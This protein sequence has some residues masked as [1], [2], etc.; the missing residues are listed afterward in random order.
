MC[1]NTF[2]SMRRLAG[3]VVT[4]AVGVLLAGCA[5]LGN[6][7]MPGSAPMDSRNPSLKDQLTPVVATY[8]TPTVTKAS[9]TAT[10]R[11][12]SPPRPPAKAVI[13]G[14]TAG[15]EP[16]DGCL[17]RLKALLDEPGRKWV[18]QPQSPVEHAD[19]TRQFAYRALRMKLTCNELALA[20]DQIVAATK[21]FRTSVQGVASDQVARIRTLDAQIEAELRAERASRCGT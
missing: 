10:A 20:I 5:V 6:L 16:V 17:M 3:V 2:L 19:G 9:D 12:I 8:P 11:P 15:C 4:I 13:D 21:T 18:G 7:A 1:G 14:S